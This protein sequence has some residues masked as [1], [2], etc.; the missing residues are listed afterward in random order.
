M[1]SDKGKKRGPK[2]G[3]NDVRKKPRIY[4]HGLWPA[5]RKPALPWITGSETMTICRIPA[6]RHG[7]VEMIFPAL[8]SVEV[9]GN[10][11]SSSRRT[12]SRSN[13]KTPVA[14]E[15]NSNHPKHN[16]NATSKIEA[17]C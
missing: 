10:S 4:T 9:P 13:S 5:S 17:L 1:G 16:E 3:Q 14:A 7:S 12:S 11:N 8:C 2:R 15:P 6:H